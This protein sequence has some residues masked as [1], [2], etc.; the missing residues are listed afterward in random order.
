MRNCLCK[1]EVIARLNGELEN[2]INPLM[3][4]NQHRFK[5][6][7]LTRHTGKFYLAAYNG[8]VILLIGK[9]H[10][11][12]RV[13]NRPT[14]L[15]LVRKGESRTEYKAFICLRSDRK[16]CHLLHLWH[17]DLCAKSTEH[18]P[19]ENKNNNDYSYQSMQPPYK[20]SPQYLVLLS[21]LSLPLQA[22]HKK[23]SVNA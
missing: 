13:H 1:R 10:T 19:F 17:N 6:I 4:L 14:L 21:L 16:R 15:A 8:P 2:K 23:P 20:F 5:I 9:L 18:R 7:I 11:Q 12:N 3:L 22:A